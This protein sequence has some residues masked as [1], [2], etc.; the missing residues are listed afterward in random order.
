MVKISAVFMILV[1]TISSCN[2][3]SPAKPTNDEELITTLKL[4]L[5]NKLDSTV[6]GEFVFRDEDGAGGNPPSKW[7]TL[8][9]KQG[10]YFVNAELYNESN[11][12]EKI[13]ITAEIQKEADEHL[14]F[15][16]HNLNGFT[17]EYADNYNGLPLG[18]NTNWKITAIETGKLTVVLK[19]MP[20]GIKAVNQS[21]GD[22]DL[23]VVFEIEIN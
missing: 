20:G 16:N 1:L 18:L 6:S 13:D 19:H 7:D 8:K 10:D 5:Y 3:K 4:T 21:V 14:F 23:E 2:E 22:T 9:L 12:L 17:I 15:Y 11:P